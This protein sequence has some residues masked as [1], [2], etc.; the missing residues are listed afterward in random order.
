VRGVRG[1]LRNKMDGERECVCERERGGEEGVSIQF[2]SVWN[3]AHFT[4]AP[5]ITPPLHSRCIGRIAMHAPVARSNN[6][7]I[8]NLYMRE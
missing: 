3:V 7:Q 6:A 8:V 5:P 4:C 1:G 2:V